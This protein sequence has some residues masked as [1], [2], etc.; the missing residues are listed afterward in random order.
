MKKLLLTTMIAAMLLIPLEGVAM[1]NNQEAG[2]PDTATVQEGGFVPGEVPAQTGAAQSM[3]PAV[4][5]M[6][7][8]MFHHGLTEFDFSDTELGWETLYNMLSLYGQMDERSD[9]VDEQLVLPVETVMDFSAAIYPSFSALGT[10]PADL[11]DRMVYDP[12]VDGYLV[13]CGNDSLAEIQLSD[14]QV[15]ADGSL[16]LSGTLVYL[17]DGTALAQFHAVLQPR[18][19]MFGYTIAALELAN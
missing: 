18:D 11:S 4:H 14:S 9:Y 15:G 19:N 1:A 6:I 2:S 13:T 7:L 3:T 12:E 10:L 5:A 8:A 17:V 16:T